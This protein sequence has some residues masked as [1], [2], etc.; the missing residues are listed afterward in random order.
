MERVVVFGNSGSGKSTWAAAFARRNG[1]AHL[2]LDTLAWAPDAP[3]PTRRPLDE[4]ARDI[5]RFIDAHEGWV[6]EGCYADLLEP[7]LPRCTR[8]VFLNPGVETCRANARRR[9]FEPHKYASPAAQDANLPMLLAWIGD[10]EARDD[11][12]S[13]RAHRALFDSFDGPKREWRSNAWAGQSAPT[14]EA[15]CE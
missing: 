11:A 1:A 5:E 15:R 14:P 8:L 9:P 6:V 4:A 12:F 2:D 3:R 10:Y 13:L 7:L